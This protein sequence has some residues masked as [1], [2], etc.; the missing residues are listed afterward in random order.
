[1]NFKFCLALLLTAPSLALADAAGSKLGVAETL[2]RANELGPAL[3]LNITGLKDRRGLI[4]A[5]IYPPTQEDFLG[6]DTNLMK[7]GKVF[8]RLEIPTPAS[9][10]VTLCMRVPRAGTYSIIVLHDRDANHK[11][12]WKHDGVVIGNNGRVQNPPQAAQA[13]VVA[14]GG[15]TPY[16]L[17]MQYFSLG[18]F[19]FAPL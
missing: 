5:E 7:A 9:G 18:A 16:H 12:D 3:M 17:K 11:F 1:M 14:G 13:K 2:C 4:K 8:R 10:T 15:I 19:G 6:D